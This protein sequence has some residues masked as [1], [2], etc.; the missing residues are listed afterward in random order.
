V[1]V[2]I[3]PAMKDLPASDRIFIGFEIDSPDELVRELMEHCGGTLPDPPVPKTKS[4][5]VTLHDPNGILVR[6]FPR[7]PQH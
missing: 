6:L 5:I 1:P 7:A 2:E 3:Y 4:G